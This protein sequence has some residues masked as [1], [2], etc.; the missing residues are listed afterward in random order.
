MKNNFFFFL[1]TELITIANHNYTII[2]LRTLEN[3]FGK[4]FWKILVPNVFF[5]LF[6]FLFFFYFVQI[7]F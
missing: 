6:I 4:F 3:S 1:Q 5:A 7:D 2:F